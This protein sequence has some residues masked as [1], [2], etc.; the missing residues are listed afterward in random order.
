MFIKFTDGGKNQLLKALINTFLFVNVEI[1][2]NW[3]LYFPLNVLN[4]SE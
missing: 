4:K 1:R 3:K 2:N